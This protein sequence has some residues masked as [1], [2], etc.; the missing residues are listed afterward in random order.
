[1]LFPTFMVKLISYDLRLICCSHAV[2]VNENESAFTENVSLIY[3][4]MNL[5][6]CNDPYVER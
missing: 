3:I 1:M 4:K 5:S 6:S 2:I